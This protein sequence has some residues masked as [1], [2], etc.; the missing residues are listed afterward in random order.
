MTPSSRLLKIAIRSGIYTELS[1][2]KI[3]T[4]FSLLCSQLSSNDAA[5][6]SFSISESQYR[7][8][9][10]Q[11]DSAQLNMQWSLLAVKTGQR[12]EAIYYILNRNS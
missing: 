12:A 1:R 4:V 3:N 11:S 8:I 7:Y 6:G 2:C 9:L 5:D 10:G